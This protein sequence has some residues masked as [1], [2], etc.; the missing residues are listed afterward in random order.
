MLTIKGFLTLSSLKDNASDATGMFGEITSYCRT[1]ARD[2]KEYT[3]P[4]YTGLELLVF[5]S[6]DANIPTP[7]NIVQR[8][9][10]LEVGNYLYTL[11]STVTPSWRVVDVITAFTTNFIGK[12]SEVVCGSLQSDGFR[13]LPES[14]AFRLSLPGFPDASVKLWLRN[15]AFES[16]YDEYQILIV[17]PVDIL[18]NLFLPASQVAT[19]LE[20]RPIDRVMEIIETAKNKTPS[21]VTVGQPARWYNPAEAGKYLTMNWYAVIYGPKGNTTDLINEAI[22]AFILAHSIEPE[23]SWKV[24]MPDLFHNTHFIILPRWDTYAIPNRTSIAGIYSPMMGVEEGLV[25]AQS[26][27]TSW[28]GAH[29]RQ[30]AVITEHPYRSISMMIVGGPDNRNG[31]FKITQVVGDYIGVESTH[32]DFNRQTELTKQWV[33]MLGN[34]LRA[35][36]NLTTALLVPSGMRVLT[37][38]NLTYVSQKLDNIEY[39]VA[40][41]FNYAAV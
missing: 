4:S 31:L 28:T 39:M 22:V 25:F 14:I 37:R 15:S 12:V 16:Q 29:V 26:K 41:K 19:L 2:I 38:D 11:G 3:T 20:S 5:S 23:A 8:D 34:L 32:E 18:D 17:P 21:T 13:R 40:A 24:I 36:E 35:A 1:F 7:I 10:L 33:S 27:I 6:K 30:N 9:T